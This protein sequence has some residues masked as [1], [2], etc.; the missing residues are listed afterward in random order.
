[1]WGMIF[2]YVVRADYRTARELA[3]QLQRVAE[4]ENDAASLL[5]SHG[6]TCNI[7][8]WLGE[9]SSALEHAEYGME[10]YD[11]AEHSS[12]ISLYGQDLGVTCLC[13]AAYVLMMLGYVDQALACVHEARDLAKALSH[14]FSRGVAVLHT[15]SVHFVRRE[16]LAAQTHYETLIALSEE[17]GFR[18][19]LVT[20]TG[21]RGWAL[22]MQGKV[23]EGLAQI[24]EGSAGFQ[25]T[26]ARH[27]LPFFT[28]LLAEAH[29]EVEQFD[30]G[31]TLVTETLGVVDR[32]DERWYEAELHRLKGEL[33]LRQR[34]A[35]GSSPAAPTGEAEACFRQA[36]SSF[37]HA[38]EIARRQQ[39][40]WWALRATVSLCRLW[41]EQDKREEAQEM[42]AEIYGWFTEGFDTPDLLAAKELL[43]QLSN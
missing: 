38:I 1:M 20:A 40:K 8:F 3:E 14:P 18:F 7:L 36:E 43:A 12:L 30:E 4:R 31:L 28:I 26:G 42:L 27:L 15:A 34:E 9:F 10:L 19:W 6:I 37:Q 35:R 16:V 2:Y 24:R 13:F 39:A 11:Q 23:E 22:A 17:H 33:L 25:A 41:R 32:T 5:A 29:G 21:G